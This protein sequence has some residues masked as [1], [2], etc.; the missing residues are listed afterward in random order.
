MTARKKKLSRITK[1]VRSLG[2]KKKPAH[3]QL[4]ATAQV[5]TMSIMQ[6]GRLRRK[7]KD[8]MDAIRKQ[9]P[10]PWRVA[11]TYKGMVTSKFPWMS[12][13]AVASKDGNYIALCKTREIARAI[14]KMGNK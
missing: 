13:W 10:T 4:R 6:L 5:G 11:Y 14:C 9:H 12:D 7:K 2:P 1:Y 3:V 8:P